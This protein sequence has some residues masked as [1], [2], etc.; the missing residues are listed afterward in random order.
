[1]GEHQSRLL[2][3]ERKQIYVEIAIHVP[4]ER[5]WTLSQDPDLHPRWDLRFSRIIPTSR[6]AEGLTRFRYEFLLP[7]RTITGTGIS[8]GHRFRGDGQATSV[9]KFFTSDALSPIGPGSGYW[10]Y[11]PTDQAIRFVT[12]Y[13]YEPG[14]GRLGKVLDGRVVRPL[15][16]WATAISFDRLRL[17]AESDV[18][19]KESRNRWIIDATA[20]SAGLLAATLVIRQGFDGGRPGTAVVLGVA[21]ATASL[22][23]PRHWTVPRAGRCLR[24]APDRLSARAPSALASLPSPGR[25]GARVQSLG[26]E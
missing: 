18:D 17:W 9:L 4:M 22:M 8:L 3:S 13:N 21:A 24:R 6:D 23:I 11:I 12:G 20:R 26:Q 2:S 5:L 15:L 19:P 1:M 25:T 16:G 14:M 7:F 10:R